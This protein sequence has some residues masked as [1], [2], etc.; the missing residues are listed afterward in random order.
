VPA[1]DP[2]MDHLRDIEDVPAYVRMEIEHFF[3]VY[4]E[5]EPGKSVRGEAWANRADA[6]AE[7]QRSFGRAREDGR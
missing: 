1:G 2:R 3:L 5:L 7:I 4:K 6:E